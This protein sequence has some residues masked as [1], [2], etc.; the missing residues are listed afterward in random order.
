M[1]LVNRKAVCFVKSVGTPYAVYQV[2]LGDDNA[3]T[4]MYQTAQAS[5]WSTLSVPQFF[6]A[7]NV[8]H[9]VTVVHDGPVAT[10]YVDPFKN[11]FAQ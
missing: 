8:S 7:V 9:N 1:S 11:T 3:S 2:R 4:L 6:K 10:V 5:G